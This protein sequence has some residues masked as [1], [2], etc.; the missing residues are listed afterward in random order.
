MPAQTTEKEELPAPQ[1]VLHALGKHGATP[2]ELCERLSLSLSEIELILLQLELDGL[3]RVS[4]GERYFS[5]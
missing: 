2:E 4:A 5:L 1:R 3:V